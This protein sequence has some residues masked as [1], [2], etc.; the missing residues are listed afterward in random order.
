MLDGIP[1]STKVSG[2]E[3]SVLASLHHFRLILK[4]NITVEPF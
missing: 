4:G 3:N 1:C 2:L